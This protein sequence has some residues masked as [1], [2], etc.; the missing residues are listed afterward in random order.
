MFLLGFTFA[1]TNEDNHPDN[2]KIEHHLELHSTKPRLEA[3]RVL[4]ECSLEH[5]GGEIVRD[6][7]F[8]V[9]GLVLAVPEIL[10]AVTFRPPIHVPHRLETVS[11]IE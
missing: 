4:W 9:S 3:G 1:K 8:Y 7:V 2:D 5:H 10:I 11:E 6:G